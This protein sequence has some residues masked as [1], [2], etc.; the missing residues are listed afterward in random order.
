MPG[1]M[2]M[3]RPHSGSQ[4]ISLSTVL[5]SSFRQGNHSTT[6]PTSVVLLLCFNL[7]QAHRLCLAM[8]SLLKVEGF[9]HTHAHGMPLHMHVGVCTCISLPMTC[10]CTRAALTRRV[11][12]NVPLGYEE[13]DD[14]RGAHQAPCHALLL[15]SHTLFASSRA[16]S[17]SHSRLIAPSQ[18]HAEFLATRF[19]DFI[20]DTFLA[21]LDA[22]GNGKLSADELNGAMRYT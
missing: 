3:S 17:P 10:P 15:P 4:D 22:D 1:P 2:H 8:A 13:V 9:H 21:T 18:V 16:L 7:M 19:I 6:H 11:P 20:F 12:P 14:E 5:G